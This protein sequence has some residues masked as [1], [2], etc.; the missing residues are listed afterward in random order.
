MARDGSRWRVVGLLALGVALGIALTASPATSHV[1][2]GAQ[3][4]AAHQAEGGRALPPRRE[5][6]Q[7]EGNPRELRN[8]RHLLARRRAL[9][10]ELLVRI[11]AP[12]GPDAAPPDGWPGAFDRLSGK[13]RESASRDRTPLHL[14]ASSVQPHRLFDHQSGDEPGELGFPLGRHAAGDL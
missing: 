14:R 6:A 11:R 7:G 1:A 3:L 5:P 4:E 12:H 2:L 13:R 10:G 8:P 9:C